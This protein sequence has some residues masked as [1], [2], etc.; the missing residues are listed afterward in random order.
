MTSK[1]E[2]AVLMERKKKS[3]CYKTVLARL[4]I[5]PTSIMVTLIDLTFAKSA[6][7]TLVFPLL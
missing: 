5:T 3:S 2:L 4:N 7:L 6:P 1:Q